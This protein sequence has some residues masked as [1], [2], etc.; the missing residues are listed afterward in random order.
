MPQISATTTAVSPSTEMENRN[1]VNATRF[2]NRGCSRER[3]DDCPRFV[4]KY[5]SFYLKVGT[6]N[7]KL[8]YWLLTKMFSISRNTERTA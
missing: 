8:N 6:K 1:S 7:M 5:S 2:G 3:D 4:D